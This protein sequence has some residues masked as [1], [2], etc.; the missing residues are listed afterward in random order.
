MQK[1]ETRLV[2]KILAFHVNRV[3]YNCVYL[4]TFCGWFS[5]A[6]EKLEAFK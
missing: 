2:L 6:F 4:F 3:V 1:A 5:F